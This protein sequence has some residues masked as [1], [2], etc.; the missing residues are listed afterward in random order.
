MYKEVTK[1]MSAGDPVALGAPVREQGAGPQAPCTE[2]LQQGGGG[3]DEAL[4]GQG[5]MEGA[6]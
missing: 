5:G 2:R 6:S 4:S 1:K 3:G